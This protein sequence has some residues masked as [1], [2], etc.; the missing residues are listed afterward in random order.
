MRRFVTLLVIALAACR[1]QPADPGYQQANAALMQQDSRR[2]LD[3]L[4]DDRS[5]EAERLKAT[6]MLQL[7]DMPGAAR[8][9]DRAVAAGGNAAVY[10]DY[11]RLELIRGRIAPAAQWQQRAEQADPNA[12]LPLL[13]GG[14]IAMARGQP[15][16]A[17]NYA[18]RA[19]AGQPANAAAL[20]NRAHA[21][22]ALRRWDELRL[23]LD[24]LERELPGDPELA[25]L[26]KALPSA[27]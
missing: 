26:R 10:A 11:A 16:L 21:L 12:L 13:I 1:A 14:E 2:V 15:G 22:A 18:D 4:K 8:Y 25:A 20:T 17:L 6:A 19:L 3:L 5:A 23:L 27:R 24:R 7:Q 9:L